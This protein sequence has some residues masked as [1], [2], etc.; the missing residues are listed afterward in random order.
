M[1]TASPI[2]GSQPFSTGIVETCSAWMRHRHEPRWKRFGTRKVCGRRLW[3]L[4]ESTTDDDRH[5]RDGSCDADGEPVRGRPR[6]LLEAAAGIRDVGGVRQRWV[7]V[8]RR[9][10]ICDLFRVMYSVVHRRTVS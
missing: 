3:T 1:S 2:I 6:V 4:H 9:S 10:Y 5:Q 8:L 7:V